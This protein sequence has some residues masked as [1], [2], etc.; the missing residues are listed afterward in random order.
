MDE[1][2]SHADGIDP[3]RSARFIDASDKSDDVK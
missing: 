2:G 1:M 3:A